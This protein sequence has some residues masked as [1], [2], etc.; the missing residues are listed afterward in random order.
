[1]DGL[2]DQVKELESRMEK[3]EL[4]LDTNRKMIDELDSRLKNL[5]ESVDESM[6]AE[7][8]RMRM[9]KI[10]LVLGQYKRLDQVV[11]KHSSIIKKLTRNV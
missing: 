7:E 6:S 1:M 8:K 10:L 2:A 3:F 9:R 4:D 5:T 11:H